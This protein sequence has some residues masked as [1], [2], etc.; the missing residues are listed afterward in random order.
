M[1]IDSI[2]NGI[3]LDHIEAGKAMR[4]CAALGLESLDCTVAIIKNVKSEKMGRKDLIKI[5]EMID[6]DLNALGFIDPNITI[7]VIR[8]GQLSE[9][10]KLRLPR[11]LFNIVRCKNPR[12]ITT[13]EQEADQ[14]F[15]LVSENPPLYRCAYCD[16]AYHGK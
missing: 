7:N 2:C 5:D 6:L 16:A 15:C 12:C 4:I 14:I 8:E 9:K 11:E 13:V 1:K 10:K 3:V